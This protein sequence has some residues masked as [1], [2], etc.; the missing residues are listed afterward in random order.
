MRTII[1]PYTENCILYKNWKE[2]TGNETINIISGSPRFHSCLALESH[3]N[4]TSKWGVTIN[5]E[6]SK[7]LDDLNIEKKFNLGEISCLPLTLLNK[8]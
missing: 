4:P 7:K 2:K 5:E 1:C 8:I 3:N 6:I